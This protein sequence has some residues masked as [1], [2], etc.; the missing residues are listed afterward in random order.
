VSKGLVTK[1]AETNTGTWYSGGKSQW[2]FHCSCHQITISHLIFRG[3][4][5]TSVNDMHV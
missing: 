4:L 2:A 1:S 5:G 3:A